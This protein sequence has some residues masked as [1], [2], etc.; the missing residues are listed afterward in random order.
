MTTFLN[1][2]SEDEI[3]S[4]AI[5]LRR[6]VFF[7]SPVFDGAAEQ[8]IKTALGLAGLPLSGQ[9]ILFDGRSGDAFEHEVTV[10]VMDM[11]KLYLLVDDKIHA[12]SIGPYSLI[13]PLPT[14]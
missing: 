2:L 9:A 12:R 5:K 14:A 7:A 6:G 10:G 13:P 11:L 1:K 3:K 8:D 4:I